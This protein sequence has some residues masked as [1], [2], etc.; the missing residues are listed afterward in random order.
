MWLRSHV[1]VM[2]CL[3]LSFGCK[4]PQVVHGS[5]ASGGVPIAS[6][7][8]SQSAPAA[9]PSAASQTAPARATGDGQ[10]E[11]A[12][13]CNGVFAAHGMAQQTFCLCRT[14]DHGKDCR[15]GAECEGMCVLDPVRREVS[16]PGPPARGHF[17]GRCSEF[18]K[19]FG[20]ARFL[21]RGAGSSPV[22][23]SEL[24]PEICID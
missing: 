4:S 22:D 11:C 20:C 23:L 5:G 7:A 15:D 6:N 10:A 18:V 2:G 21:S 13:R 12:A 24:P 16:N 3:A 17:V 9:D 1:L 8:A 14:R 19:T